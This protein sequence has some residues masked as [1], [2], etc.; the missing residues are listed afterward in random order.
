MLVDAEFFKSRIS[1]LN[2]AGDLGEYV[3]NVVKA[4][5]ILTDPAAAK[6]ASMEKRPKEPADSTAGVAEATK[7]EL[8]KT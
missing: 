5:A 6:R 4:K 2:G 1:K 7:D 3:L 8:G